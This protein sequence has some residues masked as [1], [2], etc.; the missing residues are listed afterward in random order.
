M[1]KS[2]R[3][4]KESQ[5]IVDEISADWLWWFVGWLRPPGFSEEVAN[6]AQTS[7]P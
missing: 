6:V 7:L 4:E 2:S 1:T 3:L 5:S